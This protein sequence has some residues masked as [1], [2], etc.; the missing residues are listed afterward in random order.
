M[1]DEFTKEELQRRVVY[2]A[3]GPA[4]RLA[5]A[6]RIPLADLKKRTD[7]A[8][9]QEAKEQ[10]LKTHEIA[11]ALDISTSKVGI[12]SRQLKRNFLGDRNAELTRRI[13]FMLWSEPLSLARMLQVLTDVSGKEVHKALQELLNEDRIQLGGTGKVPQYE[14]KVSVDRRVR[15]TWLARI[16]GLSNALKNV[17]DAIYARFFTDCGDEAFARTLAFRVRPQDLPRLKALYEEHIF[18]LIQELDSQAEGDPDA[19]ALS[20]SM[21]WAPH[22]LLD[23][24]NTEEGERA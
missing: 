22:N 4:V 10:G 11:E 8:Y 13:E 7:M 19:Q 16:D 17:G 5:R 1:S 6:F 12:L 2:A 21:F 24:G 9:F 23:D 14:L 3:L 15:D 18:A 20:L